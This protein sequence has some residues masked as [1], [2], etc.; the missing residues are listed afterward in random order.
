MNE[1]WYIYTIE[2]YSSVKRKE[3]LIPA[4]TWMN[5]KTLC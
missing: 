3:V 2:Y 5:P 1:V 4:T